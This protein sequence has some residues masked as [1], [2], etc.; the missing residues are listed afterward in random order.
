M[1]NISDNL[2]QVYI[3]RFNNRPDVY[4]IQWCNGNQFGYKPIHKPVTVEV[5]KAHLAGETTLGF[6]SLDKDNTSKWLCFDSDSANGQLDKLEQLFKDHHWPTIREGRRLGR[7]G[8][9]WLLF[10][11]PSS[12]IHLRQLGR[13]FLK[14]A[15]IA[16][17]QIELFPKQDKINNLGN[18]IR[19][20]FGIH[21]KPGADNARG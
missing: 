5:I 17:G 4:G 16:E 6:Y 21:K 18:L 13:L 15:G 3:D 9:L 11:K 10:D 2:I 20:P 7:D 8:H 19:A 14:K 12:A 1:D